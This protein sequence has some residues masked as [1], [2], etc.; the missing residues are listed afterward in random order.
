[1]IF[2]HGRVSH[3][4]KS[5]LNE[6]IASDPAYSLRAMAKDLG[7]SPAHL[8]QIINNKKKLAPRTR[9]KVAKQ[10]GLDERETRY[11][12]LLAQLET[13][14]SDEIR[15]AI[16][17]QLAEI[18]TPYEDQSIDADHF[19]AI[20]EWYHIPILE[21]CY[22]DGFVC[23]PKAVSQRLGL[24]EAEVRT[25]LDRLERLGLLTRGAGDVYL[26]TEQNYSFR[27]N[28][29]NEAFSD[30][31]RQMMG[32]AVDAMNRHPIESRIMTS[33]TFCIDRSQL[34]E[35]RQL[36]RDYMQRM[37]GLFAK[38]P[39]RDDTYQLNV[40]FFNLTDGR[41]KDPKA[42]LESPT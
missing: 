37:A 18:S 42:A 11:F 5:V 21:M 2:D 40:Q 26:R 23:T 12:Y 35:A 24:P 38:A 17:K 39:R 10:L 16:E 7:I 4:L 14:P 15:S 1:V 34:D 3:Y 31:L 29:R 25:A 27:T 36:T 28:R 22:L 33:Y 41:E 6:R 13:A 32:L 30:F 20:S 9:L 19:R 8:S